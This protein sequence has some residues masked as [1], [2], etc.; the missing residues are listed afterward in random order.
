MNQKAIFFITAAALLVLFFV[1][2]AVVQQQQGAQ[3]SAAMDEKQQLLMRS[4]APT[5]GPK[6]AKVTIVEF[7]DPACET[8][9]DFYG[10][11]KKLMNQYPGKVNLV[12][13]YAPFHTGSDQVVA[14]LEAANKQGKFWPALELLFKAQHRWVYKH[15]SQP[16]RA[17]PLLT[18]LDLDK[19]RFAADMNSPE[20][21]KIVQKELQDAQALGV[22][23][24]PE[25]FVN[26]TPMPSFGYKQLSKLV[27]DAVADAY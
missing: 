10:L 25:F 3:K 14:M 21:Q 11:V 2:G 15:Q 23:A 5:K 27:A 7:L 12:V 24:T 4:G 19:E 1:A 13:R 22:R 20:V 6:D 26:G 17:Y 16:M 9:R 18:T 8:C